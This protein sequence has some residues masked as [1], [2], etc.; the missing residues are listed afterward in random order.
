MAPWGIAMVKGH[1]GKE[2]TVETKKEQREEAKIG[3]QRGL[4]KDS[5]TVEGECLALPDHLKVQKLYMSR[6]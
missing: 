2:F 3:N 1:V 4:Q 6:N 5:F